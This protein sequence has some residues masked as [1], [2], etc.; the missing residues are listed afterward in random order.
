MEAN[1]SG[2]LKKF[3]HSTRLALPLQAVM[4]SRWLISFVVWLLV[5]VTGCGGAHRYDGRL[6]LA[7]SLMQHSPDS[8]LALVEA[9]S[10]DS[11]AAGGDRAYRDLLLTQARYK[12]YIAATSDSAI[13]R[14]LNYYRQHDDEREKLT[15]A[16]IYKG[17][18]ME[19]LGHPDSAML[20][21]KTA[22]ATADTSDYFNLGYIKIRMA[23]LY[24]MYYDLDGKSILK[25]EE[26][27]DYFT[28]SNNAE[29]Q[30]LCLNNLGC[31]YRDSKPLK[32][33][34]LIKE[35]LAISK[36][37]NNK[38]RI[39][40]GYHALIILYF[41]QH[42]NDKALKLVREAAK[43]N[44][45]DLSFDYCTTA[46][47]VYSRAGLL[48][49][50]MLYLNKAKSLYNPDVAEHK[51]YLLESLSEIALSK[52]D[53]ANYLNLSVQWKHIS[54]SLITNS[55]K[56][57]ITE[58]EEKMNQN[59]LTAM[60]HESSSSRQLAA[61]IIIAAI[62]AIA[63]LAV[64]FFLLTK[65]RIGKFQREIDSTK[66][67][68]EIILRNLEQERLSFESER[69]D[70]ISQIEEKDS[71]LAEVNKRKRQLELDL[72]Q[73]IAVI[74]RHRYSAINELYNCIRIKTDSDKDRKRPLLLMSTLR[75]LYEKKGVLT[76]PPSQSF[77]DSLRYS[78]EGEYP[79][80]MEFINKHYPDL[81]E[82]DIKL[83]L[84]CCSDFPN[85]I[86]KICMNY[87]S[88]VT[89]SKN[90]KKLLKEKF[91]LDMKFDDFIRLYLQGKLPLH[92]D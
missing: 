35:A 67:E 88:D 91:G 87:T 5:A 69:Q 29:Y 36:K 2:M 68:L 40:E 75:D 21:Y 71:E 39:I 90:K 46:A 72:N 15:R 89:A 1:T 56:M 79:G 27:L 57:D 45:N 18:V 61:F 63:L 7:D 31:L 17:A 42:H 60:N 50:A 26:A 10:P 32:A 74:V 20:Y 51:M 19:E 24:D 48:D 78:V 22:E 76:T 92:K 28:K 16:Y 80:I 38:K 58:S 62:F 65:N 84:L 85:K 4:N 52:C 83:L 14:A 73:R 30:Y 23:T 33:E 47:N 37:S 44:W 55:Q 59:T 25:Y 41:Y 8:A 6:V 49:S 9:V 3:W 81:T 82:D 86:I 54:D 53:T 66:S 34:Q 64:I 70:F 13:N 77:W 12:C 11:L 43:L